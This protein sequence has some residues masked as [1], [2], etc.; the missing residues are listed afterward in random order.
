MIF[1]LPAPNLYESQGRIAGHKHTPTSRESLRSLKPLVPRLKEL[2]IAKVICAELDEATGQWLARRL[3]VPYESWTSLNR[4]NAGKSHGIKSQAWSQLMDT[5]EVMWAEKPDVPVK[6]GDSRTSFTR[7]M[8][9][10]RERL[11]KPGLSSASAPAQVLVVAPRQVIG[12]LLQQDATSLIPGRV[13][14]A[15]L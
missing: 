9:A 12:A 8:A 4:F 13:Y 5:M 11:S 2:N 6:G 1:A 15:S 14:Q 7:R 3:N 10:S